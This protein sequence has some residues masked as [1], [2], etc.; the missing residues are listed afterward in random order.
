MRASKPAARTRRQR[1]PPDR[2]ERSA[3]QVVAFVRGLIERKEL[4]PGDRLPPERDLAGRLGV[5]RPTVRMAL[6]ALAAMGVVQSR[7]GS[8]TYIPAGPPALGSEPLSLLAALHDFT[9]AQM[10]DARRIFEV[11]AAGLAAECATPEQI[12]AL[13]EEVAGLFAS[14]DDPQRFLVH[15]IAFH[16]RVAAASGN[17]IVAAVVEMVAAL[18][19]EQ[20]RTTAGQASDRDLRDAAESHRE[21]YKAIKGRKVEA[22]RRAMNEHLLRA[23]AYQRQERAKRRRAR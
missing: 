9:H 21:I 22:A 19:Y 15:D 23:S 8:G 14:M 1:R 12:A 4:R 20:R 17:P 13:A 2:A 10:Y 16:R 11:G 7:H 3:E 6:Q 18:Y 5:S